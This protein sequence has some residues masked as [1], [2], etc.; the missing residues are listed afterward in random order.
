MKKIFFVLILLIT[1][2]SQAQSSYDLLID[3]NLIGQYDQ[4]NNNILDPSELSNISVLDLGGAGY[5]ELDVMSMFP[6]L[7]ILSC[8]NN[9]ITNLDLSNNT[10]LTQLNCNN[11][12]LTSL[13]LSNNTALIRLNC[14]NN[15][16]TSLNL[17]KSTNLNYLEC[18][19]NQLTNLD[20]SKAT[21]VA[22]LICDNNN[23]TNLNLSKSTALISLNCN[24]NKL[25]SLDVANSSNIGVLSCTNNP[26]GT[27]CVPSVSY[28]LSHSG[29]FKKPSTAVWS[30]YC[31]IIPDPIFRSILLSDTLI[32]TNKNQIIEPSEASSVIQL[33]VSKQNISNLTG[34]ELFSNLEKLNC[35]INQLSKL[36]VSHNLKLV[37]LQCGGNVEITTINLSK[38]TALTNLH[39]GGNYKIKSLDLSENINLDTLNCYFNQ[40]TNLDLSHNL[41]IKKVSCINTQINYLDVTANKELTYLNCSSNFRN[42]NVH[43]RFLNASNL[44]KLKHLYCSTNSLD[45]LNI[46][47]DTSLE[48]LTCGRFSSLTSLDLSTNTNL[49]SLNCSISDITYLDVSNNHKLKKLFCYSSKIDSLN[50]H[51]ADSLTILNCYSNN[52]TN[53]DIS[54]NTVL[55]EVYCYNNRTALNINTVGAKAL[56]QLWCYNSSLLHLDLS[57]NTAL[58][59][60]RCQNN[61]LLTKL[62]VANGNNTSLNTFYSNDNPKLSCIQTDDDSGVTSSW[63]SKDPTTAYSK[64]CSKITGIDATS[65]ADKLQ[66]YPNPAKNTLHLSGLSIIS[67][68]VINSKGNVIKIFV[69]KE[70][71]DISSLII[72]IYTLQVQTPSGVVYKRFVK[73]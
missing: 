16:L 57:S 21:N 1:L 15:Q 43:P 5:F 18:N 9:N 56:E 33:D 62:S 26:L 45:S 4:N 14:N 39:T 48:T 72:G 25:S 28:A 12:Q 10:A 44:T 60:L 2:N 35:E 13:D 29:Q 50:L 47:G 70:L 58:T 54:N 37:N 32:N 36:D 61:Q 7:N 66:L 23:L 30:D 19:D 17:S 55:E 34:I 49:K 71:I 41:K 27:I 40:I 46:S 69:N 53:L 65:L 73:E 11:N 59:D 52:L 67:S 38:N 31:T 68:T 24:N 20:L 8:E 63:W 3:A 42:E 51:G 22:N 64:D 6:N